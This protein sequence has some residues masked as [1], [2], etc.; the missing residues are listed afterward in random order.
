M[1]AL[2]S[3]ADIVI[4]GAAA[5]VGKTFSLLL[6]PLR[7]VNNP[8]FGA[9]CFRRTSPQIRAEGGLWDTSQQLY[10]FAAG[11]PKETTLEWT[12]PKGA[13]V[14]FSHLQHESDIYNWQGAQIAL[15][16]FDELTHFTEKQF[17]YMLSRNRSTCG[18]R[19]YVRATCNP[20][21]ESWVARFISWWIDEETGFPIP[22]RDG[23]L[24]Y[25][26][27]HGD[28]FIWGDSKDEVI[29][30]AWFALEPL[31]TESGIAAEEFVKSVTFIS[32]RIYDNKEL[33]QKDPGY[34]ANLNAQD[35][36]TKLALLAGNW[37]VVISDLDI[38]DYYALNGCFDNVKAVNESGRYITADIA[39]KGSNKFVVGA[40][41][42]F[43]LQEVSVM[44]KSDGREVVELIERMAKVHQVQNRHIVFDADGVGG[45]I[46]G[47][48]KGAQPFHG[49]AAAMEAKADSGQK[50]KENY[51]NLKAQCFYR[52]GG[53][54]GRGEVAIAAEVGHSMYDKKMTHR[55]RILHER[56][57]IKRYKA[58]SDGKLRL[59]PKDEM[60]VKL[61]G[62]SPDYMDMIAMRE[63]FELKP[64]RQWAVA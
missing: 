4:G 44:P 23:V 47:F 9:V 16:M 62:E 31:V 37:K 26:T 59:L 51:E 54:V 52:M 60:K 57:A 38:F 61:G 15:L 27:R 5:G 63:F 18:V 24:R 39:L 11:N 48:I 3:P 19:P 17:F 56:K 6:E 22:E 55:Q 36:E 12:F 28:D 2:A 46:D 32:G 43:K 20:D 14:N 41:H 34:L 50:Q 25:F 33:L 42:G 10:R 58:D 29:E 1:R 35:E 8:D 7:H 21:P 45:F 13:R 30:K 64:A 53:R 49:G 40:W